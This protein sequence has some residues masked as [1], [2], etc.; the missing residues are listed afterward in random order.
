[1]RAKARELQA[2]ARNLPLVRA[3]HPNEGDPSL[4]HFARIDRELTWG[5]TLNK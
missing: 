3:P 4:Q 2:S 1:M 5:L